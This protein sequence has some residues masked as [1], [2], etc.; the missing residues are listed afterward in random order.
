MKWLYRSLESSYNYLISE[1]AIKETIIAN[2]Y[3]FYENG[4]IA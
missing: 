2:E 3:D 4:K 1:E